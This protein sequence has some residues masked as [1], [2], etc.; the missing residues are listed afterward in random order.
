LGK[1][2]TTYTLTITGAGGNDTHSTSLQLT[3][4]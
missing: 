2:S 1:G 3:V 4:Q